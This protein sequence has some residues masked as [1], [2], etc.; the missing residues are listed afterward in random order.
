[1]PVTI[2]ADFSTTMKDLTVELSTPTGRVFTAVAS[3]IDLHT[4]DGTIHI[5]SRDG[6]HLNLT[7]ATKITF[8]TGEGPYAFMLEN[9]AA[10]LNGNCFTVLA[11]R[12]QRVEV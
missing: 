7:H 10:G 9:A 2:N 6:S 3:S 4:H 5:T 12:I 11:E 1:M 8:Q